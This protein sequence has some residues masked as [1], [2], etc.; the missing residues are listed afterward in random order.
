[1]AAGRRRFRHSR[2]V[3]FKLDV[4]LVGIRLDFDSETSSRKVG[5]PVIGWWSLQTRAKQMA[6]YIPMHT[7]HQ[8]PQSQHQ[9]G[10]HLAKGRPAL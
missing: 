10:K 8:P 1:M 9:A 3:W 2:N 6:P 5:D 7:L 4:D